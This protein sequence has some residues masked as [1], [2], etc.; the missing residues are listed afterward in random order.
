MLYLGGMKA[1]KLARRWTFGSIDD[2]AGLLMISRDTKFREAR[3]RRAE[4]G[5][6]AGRS[7][8]GSNGMVRMESNSSLNDSGR[9][10]AW[11][12][13]AT[14]RDATGESMG[15]AFVAGTGYQ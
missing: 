7:R 8:L 10:S 15:D 1:D 13:G 9:L 2:N 6:R 11:E 5:P 3:G 14:R 12:R 4:N